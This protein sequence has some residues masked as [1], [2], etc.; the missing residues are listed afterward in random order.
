[1]S[2][3]DGATTS[4]VER[5]AAN[6]WRSQQQFGFT[7]GITLS[8]R[9]DSCFAGSSAGHD[10]GS[11]GLSG[12]PHRAAVIAPHLP[13]DIPAPEGVPRRD[14]AGGAGRT[15]WATADDVEERADVLRV[16]SSRSASTWA[17][18]ATIAVAR[19]SWSASRVSSSPAVQKTIAALRLTAEAPPPVERL[20]SS[21]RPTGPGRPSPVISSPASGQGLASPQIRALRS[22]C[23]VVVV[24]STRAAVEHVGTFVSFLHAEDEG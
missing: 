21:T 9:S 11:R 24:R 2:A 20:R 17:R 22:S 13:P 8:G 18:S 3:V 7:Q 14:G 19:R 1:M 16:R 23:R 5:T 10:R 6:P 12:C 15:G 4:A